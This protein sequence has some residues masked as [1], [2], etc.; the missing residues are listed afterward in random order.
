MKILVTSDWHGDHVTH[1]VRRFAEIS[2]AVDETVDVAIE[3]GC[4]GYVFAGDLCDPDIGSPSFRVVEMA[5]KAALRLAA[6]SIDSVWVAGN[7]DVIE[8]GSLDTTLS[9]LRALGPKNGVHVFEEPGIATFRQLVDRD[10]YRNLAVVALPFTST[11]RP[12]DPAEVVPKLLGNRNPSDV[13]VVGH[14][15]VAGV[16]PGEET[17]EMPRGRD[18]WLPLRAIGDWEHDQLAR[19][20]GKR[21]ATIANGH[22][23][24]QQ[25][26]EEGVW[27]PGSL[28]RLTFCEE[29][30]SPGYLVLEV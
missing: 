16:E 2:A 25:R 10:E 27:I 18:V 28:A 30:N 29:R 14:L 12:Y 23:H 13:L 24:R 17:T 5:L 22:Y 19:G 6:A 11:T 20:H 8:D 3:E 1:G 9:P 4:A 21:R 15:H 7:H 26:T